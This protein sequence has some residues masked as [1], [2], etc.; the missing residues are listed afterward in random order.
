MKPSSKNSEYCCAQSPDFKIYSPHLNSPTLKSLT[1]AQRMMA[2]SAQTASPRRALVK[3]SP[4]RSPT[5]RIRRVR[6]EGVVD[7]SIEVA[8]GGAASTRMKSPTSVVRLL[9]A[10]SPQQRAERRS[11]AKERRQLHS[12]VRKTK[13]YSEYFKACQQ[14]LLQRL[15]SEEGKAFIKKTA[16][17]ERRTISQVVE[18]LVHSLEAQSVQQYASYYKNSRQARQTKA[19]QQGNQTANS[20]GEPKELEPSS[21]SLESLAA[22]AQASDAGL[23]EASLSC[24][25]EA[26]YSSSSEQE[27]E[28]YDGHSDS[29]TVKSHQ[30][31]LRSLRQLKKPSTQQQQQATGG[32]L[33]AVSRAARAQEQVARD[34]AER[35]QAFALR[36]LSI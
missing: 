20:A 6:S 36:R 26:G 12:K 4:R 2:A 23:E 3:R 5:R 28:D 27:E 35:M 31:P 18:R 10:L 9:Q 25:S 13:K 22:A 21:H 33:D 32:C 19:L 34:E 16:A 30:K 14:S 24:S 8:D 7:C 15:T 11:R 17:I 1:S 29:R